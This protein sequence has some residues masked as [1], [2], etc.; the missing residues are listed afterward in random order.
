MFEIIGG[1]ANRAI[2]IGDF[3]P[4]RDFVRLRGYAAGAGAMALQTAAIGNVGEVL[5]LY[6][7]TT[8]TFQGVTN[9]TDSSFVLS[10]R[11]HRASGGF[12]FQEDRH[13]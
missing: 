4:A 9:L 12:Q 2:T 7:G 10:G 13:E 6:D 8:L 5:T 1:T 11:R 3:N